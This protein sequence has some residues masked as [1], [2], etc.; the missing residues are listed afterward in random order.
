LRGAATDRERDDRG[1]K[2]AAQ[3]ALG[4]T[5]HVSTGVAELMS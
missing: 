2:K 3:G 1:A 5:D 4:P